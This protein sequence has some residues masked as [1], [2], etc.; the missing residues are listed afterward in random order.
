VLQVQ[1]A[2]QGLDRDRRA[3]EADGEVWLPG[4][5]E[6]LV[7]EVG[8]DLGEFGRQAAD[9]GWQ[10]PLPVGRRR[11]GNAKHRKLPNHLE[12]ANSSLCH[13][14]AVTRQESSQVIAP[15]RPDF[16]RGK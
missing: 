9:L 16:F 7:I 12:G 8:V 5:D 14:Q 3:A 6:A 2:Q 15:V 1:Q 10:Q 4:G 11:A 13:D